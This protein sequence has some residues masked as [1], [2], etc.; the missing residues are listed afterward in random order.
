MVS[1]YLIS[2]DL[3]RD[4]NIWLEQQGS[5]VHVLLL[6]HDGI[7]CVLEAACSPG[8]LYHSWFAS[9]LLTWYQS[10]V[11]CLWMNCCGRV[12]KTLVIFEDKRNVLSLC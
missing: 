8:V 7:D 5:Y 1:S 2:S 10:K 9:I 11:Q 4:Q 12:G 3:C 6:L